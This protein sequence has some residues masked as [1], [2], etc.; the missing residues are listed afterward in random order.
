MKI[1]VAVD[2]LERVEETVENAARWGERLGGRIDLVYIEDFIPTG[3]PFLEPTVLNLVVG[4]SKRL[5]GVYLDRLKV[6]SMRIAAECRGDVHVV[7]GAPAVEIAALSK[8]YDLVVMTSHQR[9]GLG[10]IFVGSV[11]ERVVRTAH[12]ATLVVPLDPVA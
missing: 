7:S 5:H 2:L 3:S 4:E 8:G 6:L 9:T 11:A 12:C 10:Q 1:L